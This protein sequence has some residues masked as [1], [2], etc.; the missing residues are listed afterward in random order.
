MAKSTS[1]EITPE[2]GMISRGKYTLVIRLAL[3]KVQARAHPAQAAGEVLPGDQ[4]G[5]RK[6]R[7]GRAVRRHVEQHAE[8]HREHH[9]AQQ[10]LQHDPRDAE[11]GLSCPAHFRGCSAP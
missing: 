7:I 4:R 3:P 9:R 1:V 6:E 8:D 5:E 2:S 10:R 11:R